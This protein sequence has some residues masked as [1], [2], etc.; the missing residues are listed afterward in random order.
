MSNS[1][2]KILVVED[3]EN[4]G[5][6]LRD[7]LEDEGYAV[8]LATNGAQARELLG[9]PPE[10]FDLLMLDIMLPDTNGYDLCK[11]A[12]GAG[13]S[14][15]VMML[16][17]RS[18]EDDLVQ[19]FDAGA[20]DYITKPY[21]LRELLVRIKALLR[22]G[23]VPPKDD[24]D[25]GNSFGAYT[26]NTGAR[27]VHNLGEP[28]D[29][30]R[31]EFDLLV[32]LSTHPDRALTRRELLDEVWGQDIS[33]D[34]RTVDNFVSSLKKKLSWREGCGFRIRTI[35]GVGYRFEFE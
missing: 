23:G 16:T 26:I 20:D 19:G 12:R 8:E 11:W 2:S 32:Y 27:E 18:L 17:A 1:E 5:L 14:G 22:R 15:M 25:G 6:V 7:N 9:S 35:R 34:E 4:L 31:T 13:Y 24:A 29:L 28:V 30:T 10:G 3:D 21:R 33:I